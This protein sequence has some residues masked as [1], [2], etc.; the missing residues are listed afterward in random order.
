[1]LQVPDVIAHEVVE[2]CGSIG[3]EEL[4]GELV[5]IVTHARTQTLLLGNRIH[6]MRDVEIVCTPELHELTPRLLLIS[7]PLHPSIL[8]IALEE[9]II[10]KPRSHEALMVVGG[11]VDQMT[12]HLLRRP[13]PRRRTP[14]GILITHRQKPLG[15]MAHR[16][17]KIIRVAHQNVRFSVTATLELDHPRKYP[18]PTNSYS[19]FHISYLFL[20]HSSF[21][22]TTSL[23]PS[24]IIL[25]IA[26]SGIASSERT[27]MCRIPFPFPSRRPSGSAISDPRVR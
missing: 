14:R 3:R 5:K 1:M 20:H 17:S 13:L 7:L 21:P 11:G 27:F 25:R 8:L 19:L 18:Q 15:R 24:R 9:K 23:F 16:R 26:F 10:L 22:P 12:D 2:R 6:H 4:P